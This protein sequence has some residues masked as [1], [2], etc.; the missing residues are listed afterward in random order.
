[1]KG[2]RTFLGGMALVLVAACGGGE[3][4]LAAC[5]DAMRAQFDAAMA[6][7]NAEEGTRPAECDGVSDA[8]LE[9]IAGEIIG[10]AFE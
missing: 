10:D 8:D 6:D 2:M 9:R 4:D 1:M 7:P 5:E 3:P